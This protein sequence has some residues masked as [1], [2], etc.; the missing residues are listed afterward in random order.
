LNISRFAC[1]ENTIPDKYEL[2]SN[3]ASSNFFYSGIDF[4]NC[5][6]A[7]SGQIKQFFSETCNT[8]RL[9]QWN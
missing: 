4:H 2:Y 8:K 5:F 1:S 3:Y 6:P 9:Q 7:T